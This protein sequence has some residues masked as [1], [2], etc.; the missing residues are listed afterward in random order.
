MRKKYIFITVSIII[1]I[2]LIYQFIIRSKSSDEYLIVSGRVE[3]EEIE[4]SA[5]IPGKLEYVNIKDGS[6]IKKNDIIA[7]IDNSELQ[8][9][10]KQIIEAIAELK[11]KI[12]AAEFDLDY[13][14]KNIQNSI[15]EAKKGLLIAKARLKQA[16][17]KKEN[18]EMELKRYKNLL[19]KEVIS[20]EKFDNVK[21]SYALTQE[22]VT[23][24]QKEVERA[25]VSLKKAEEA[26][27]LVMAKERELIAL[28][29]SLNQLRQT[30]E[31]IK[32]NIDYS[33]ITA[34]SDG[35]ILK[36]TAEPGEVLLQGSV[37]GIMINPEDIYVKTYVPE[38]YIGKIHI[39][40]KVDVFSDAYPDHPFKG[41]ICYI[42]DRA[43]FTPK[44]VQSYEERIKQVFEV[45]ICFSEKSSKGKAYHE[46]FKKGMPVDVIFPVKTL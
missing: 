43:E 28:K 44:E 22:E 39:N 26:E 31:Q 24:A 45:K 16:E 14:Q 11:E 10:H 30:L 29:R 4:I 25:D 3:A 38:I 20:K 34:P 23:V 1:F 9:K 19:E 8:S 46:V 15:E 37:I 13:T 5:R 12:K 7:Q 18:A 36:K 33:K 42:S 35:V 40:M 17:A 6:N 21:L 2:F 41:L 32:I 27:K